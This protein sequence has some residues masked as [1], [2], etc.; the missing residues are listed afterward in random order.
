MVE[1]EM[2]NSGSF[3]S[4][5]GVVMIALLAFIVLLKIGMMIIT[6]L[7]G[8]DGSPK[9]IDGMVSGSEFL[10]IQQDPEIS[11]SKTI[12]RSINATEGIE[13]TWSCW[14][15]LDDLGYNENQY[16]CVFYKGNDYSENDKDTSTN[17]LNFPNNS[18][19]LYLTPNKNDLVVLMNT[20]NVINEQILIKDVPVKKWVNV[21]IRCQ[22]NVIDVY[23]NGTIVKSHKLHGVPKQNYGNV[24][25]GADGGFSGYLSN[26][27]YYNKAL[28]IY[29]INNIVTKGPNTTMIGGNGSA[30]D[31]KNPDYLSLRW[32]FYGMSPTPTYTAT[33]NI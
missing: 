1:G 2:N 6:A 7:F 31:L 11:D 21:I 9:L 33:I 8:Y 14:I 16:R 3:L 19:G 27:W 29:E 25:V 15:Y 28:G 10:V 17:G 4:K 23:V 12:Y 22:N 5:V 18:P 13:F 24:Y 30:M 26:L 32:F 20:F